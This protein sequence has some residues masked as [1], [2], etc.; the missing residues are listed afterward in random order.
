MTD[1]ES[2]SRRSVV[3][4]A[5]GRFWFAPEPAYPLGLVRIAFGAL[6]VAWTV[7]LLPDLY[8]LFG[9]RGIT[10]D[11]SEWDYAW[12]RIRYG[13]QRS[14]PANRLGRAVGFGG[15]VDSRLAQPDGGARGIRTDPLVPTAQSVRVQLRR[16]VDTRP[17]ASPRVF[18]VRCGV[19]ARS[20]PRLGVV[21][22]GRAS[23]AV[24]DTA[25][26]SSALPRV[27][28]DGQRETGGRNMA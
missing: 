9:D 14:C 26:A 12:E 10:P 1:I 7:S 28:V 6:I 8:A 17:G 27:P 24:G 11:D 20:S 15:G 13:I 16:R 23:R 3:L 19:V 18:L 25:A 22:V 21:L 4:G 2:G 5:W